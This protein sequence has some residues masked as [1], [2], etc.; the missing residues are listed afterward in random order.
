MKK[1]ELESFVV[2]N[3]D[4]TINHEVSALNF[5]RELKVYE[6]LIL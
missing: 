5:V 6:K 2:R 3:A 1:Q 4:G